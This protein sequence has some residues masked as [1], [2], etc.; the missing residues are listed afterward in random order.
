MST[1]L[2]GKLS[3]RSRLAVSCNEN[4][5]LQFQLE[6]VKT[7]TTCLNL[8]YNCGKDGIEYANLAQAP[9]VVSRDRWENPT[10]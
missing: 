2:P 10:N 5:V 4:R 6:P 1:S 7:A 8:Q 9:P 3:Q